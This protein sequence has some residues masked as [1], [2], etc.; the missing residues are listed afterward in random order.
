MNHPG[1]AFHPLGRRALAAALLAGDALLGALPGRGDD[2]RPLSAEAV[3]EAQAKFRAERAAADK[4]GLA[5]VFS[6][7]WFG[8]ADGFARAGDAALAAGRLVEARDSF[9]KALWELPG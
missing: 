3:K 9:R 8:R 4:A 1:K 2:P 6:P 7:E 5:R